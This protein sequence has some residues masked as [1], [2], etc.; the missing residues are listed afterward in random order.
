MTPFVPIKPNILSYGF[1]ITR[2]V[3]CGKTNRYWNH[4]LR[5]IR[6]Y[7]PYRKII[8]IDDNSNEEFV[9]ADRE[10]SNIEIVKSEYPGRGE[11]LPY[12]YY[13]KNK[14][15]DYAVIIH[16]SVFFHKKINFEKYLSFNVLRLWHFN[17]DRENMENTLR[18]SSKLNNNFQLQESILLSQ[19]N[20]LGLN[21]DQWFGCFGLQCFIKHDF[22]VY[23]QSK[24]NISNLLNFVSSRLD[25]CCLERILGVIFS[26]EYKKN[27]HIKSIFGDI[28]KYE[29]WGYSYDEYEK[30]LYIKKRIPKHIIKVW[31]GR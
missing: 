25:R 14:Y 13:F 17:A 28:M 8:I 11:L 15:F 27:I 23:L 12:Y 7:Y 2:H 30:D 1:I 19:M 18:I 9:K 10:Y 21:R 24:Y 22:L 6:L 20:V 29:K 31:T 16:D 3:K 4:C 5:C 26:K